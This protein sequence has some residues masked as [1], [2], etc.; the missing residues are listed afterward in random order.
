MTEK[1]EKYW[2][3]EDINEQIEV[4]NNDLDYDPILDAPRRISFVK[5]GDR[6]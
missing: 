1:I 3:E 2:T 4:L 6:K 5:P